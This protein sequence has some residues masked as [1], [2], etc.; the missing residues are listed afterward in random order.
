MQRYFILDNHYLDNKNKV[1]V[2]KFIL[3]KMSVEF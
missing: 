2:K 1:I 3:I